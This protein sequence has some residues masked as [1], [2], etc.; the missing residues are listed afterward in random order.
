MRSIVAALRRASRG[1]EGA[2]MVEYALLVAL[3]A[4]VVIAS[5]TLL[6][7]AASTKL[8]VAAQSLSAS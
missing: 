1:E 2:T 7:S 4:L 8:N 6:G 5:V 3:I